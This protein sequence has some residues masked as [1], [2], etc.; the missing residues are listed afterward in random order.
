MPLAS[1]TQRAGEGRGTRKARSS[2]QQI[3]SVLGVGRAT[4]RFHKRRFRPGFAPWGMTAP[5]QDRGGEIT[6][7]LFS[8]VAERTNPLPSA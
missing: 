4:V 5:G 2:I 1:G 7:D 8:V 6:G 3:L